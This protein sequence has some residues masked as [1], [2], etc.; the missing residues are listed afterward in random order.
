MPKIPKSSTTINEFPPV[1]KSI[2]NKAEDDRN[3]YIN[4]SRTDNKYYVN[5]IKAINNKDIDDD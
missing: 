4:T 5:N 3:D 1:F 2:I